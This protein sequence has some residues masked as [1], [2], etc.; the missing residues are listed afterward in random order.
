M[1]RVEDGGRVGGG[2]VFLMH[3]GRGL[4]EASM[5]AV[6]GTPYPPFCLC[7]SVKFGTQL[8]SAVR[9]FCRLSVEENKKLPLL[10]EHRWAECCV[11]E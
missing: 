1:H 5:P 11:T 4:Y 3:L 10:D 8:G 6:C 9:M 7:F 2:A